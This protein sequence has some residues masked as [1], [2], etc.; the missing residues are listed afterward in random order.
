MV[1]IAFPG[2]FF[3]DRQGR[4]TSRFFE[5]FYVERNTMASLMLRIGQGRPPVEATKIATPH[6]DLTTYPS[7]PAVAPG[8]RFAIASRSYRTPAF[9]FMP[10]VPRATASLL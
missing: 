10:L 7:D 5:D 2:A 1:G 9:I 4:V 8:N 6:L 3:V